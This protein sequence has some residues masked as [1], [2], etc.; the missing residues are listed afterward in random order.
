[1]RA[2]NS[3][4]ISFW[5]KSINESFARMAI[6]GFVAQ[7]DP[8]VEQLADI[9]TAVSEAVS[10]CIIH[11]Y[12]DKTGII[13]MSAL[14]YPDGK[15]VITVKDNGCGI[16]NISQAMEPLYTTGNADERAGLGFAVMESFMDKLKVRSKIG[17]GTKVVMTKNMTVHR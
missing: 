1:M 14:L 12:S 2:I 13:V 6:S 10:N 15:L 8:T 9:K 17:A 7:I 4:K 3:V 11:A 16:G 5:S